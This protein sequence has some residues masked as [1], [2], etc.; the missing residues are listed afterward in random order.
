MNKKVIIITVVIVVIALAAGTY[1]LMSAV[2]APPP[3]KPESI[4]API[5]PNVVTGTGVLEGVTQENI[6][7]TAMGTVVNA[8]FEEG[9]HVDA[10]QVL[11]SIDQTALLNSI[12]QA[13]LALTKT[14]LAYD[15]TQ[16]S[17]NKL[18]VKAGI[19]GVITEL[20]V[21]NSDMV[22]ANGKVAEIV[23]DDTMVLSLPFIAEAADALYE[24]QPADVTIVGSF[25]TVTGSV[26]KVMSG[27]MATADGSVIRMVDINVPNPG[28]LIKG[29]KGTAVIAGVACNDAGTFD[30]SDSETVIAEVGGKAGN[31]TLD[32]GD[33][34]TRGSVIVTL[35]SDALTS[36]QQQNAVAI[37]AAQVSLND[38][39]SKLKDYNIAS[40]I[41]GTVIKKNVKRDE[42]VSAANAG[43][44]AVVADL[45]KLIFKMNVDEL[46]VGKLYEGQ[47][48][49]VTADAVPDKTY[50]GKVDFVG[51]SGTVVSGVSLYEITVSLDDMEGLKPGMN[52]NATINIGGNTK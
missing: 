1:F 8:P 27:S 10:G 12:E 28:S 14:Q 33:H 15:Q 3:P 2:N 50:S 47:S 11:Y 17:I 26:K 42:A 32:V 48:V 13:R 30:Y 31:I 51:L 25:Y 21:K 9:D 49:S 36:Q 18:T 46:D 34:V 5:I 19:D 37:T 39:N 35:A 24:G 20:N 22:A 44:L 45:S 43:Q 41:S 40:P 6:F 4:K 7:S 23:N 16:D 38:L 29:D 52:V